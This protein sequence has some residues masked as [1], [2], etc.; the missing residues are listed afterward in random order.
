MCPRFHGAELGS[1]KFFK[2]KSNSFLCI[3]KNCAVDHWHR[4][5]IKSRGHYRTHPVA[6]I[7]LVHIMSLHESQQYRRVIK[8]KPTASLAVAEE[9]LPPLLLVQFVH[10]GPIVQLPP[11]AAYQRDPSGQQVRGPA[12]PTIASRAIP[13]NARWK[14]PTQCLTLT[15]EASALRLV[16]GLSIVWL[17]AERASK[18]LQT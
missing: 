16:I 10:R 14:P 11:S 13:L 15:H 12:K 7:R 3:F 17:N 5:A 2:P 8:G 18:R 1:Q 6:C 4:R 9:L